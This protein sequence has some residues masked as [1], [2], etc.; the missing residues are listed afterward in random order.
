MVKSAG[1]IGLGNSFR[2]FHIEYERKK[3][4]VNMSL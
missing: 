2:E 3:L 1:L 4:I